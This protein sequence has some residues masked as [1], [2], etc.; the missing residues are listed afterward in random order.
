MA[1][2]RKSEKI[3]LWEH[4]E[5]VYRAGRGDEMDVLDEC[6]KKEKMMLDMHVREII[7]E[8]EVLAF[9]SHGH[10]DELEGIQICWDDWQLFKA[11]NGVK[12]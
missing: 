8:I 12:P 4:M 2:K 10:V 6:S 5:M 7:E 1:K 11:E 3:T 9:K